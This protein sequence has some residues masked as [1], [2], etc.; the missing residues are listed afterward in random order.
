MLYPLS[1]GRART[2]YG[3]QAITGRCYRQRTHLAADG[4]AALPALAHKLD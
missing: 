2:L 4:D 3:G 1:Y